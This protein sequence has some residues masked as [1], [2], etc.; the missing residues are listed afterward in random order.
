[1]LKANHGG[2]NDV[3]LSGGTKGGPADTN[4]MTIDTPIATYMIR[5]KISVV[6][7]VIN[8]LVEIQEKKVQGNKTHSNSNNPS[9]D[10][11]HSYVT[12]DLIM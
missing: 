1:M 2:T 3:G 5:I 11:Y 9:L 10:C 7:K 6:R 8:L 12:L 4:P